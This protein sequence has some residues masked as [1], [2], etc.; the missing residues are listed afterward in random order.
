MFPVLHKGLKL[1]KNNLPQFT[2]ATAVSEQLTVTAQ[3]SYME[4]FAKACHCCTYD[5]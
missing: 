3:C 4:H 2:A 1:K 5:V